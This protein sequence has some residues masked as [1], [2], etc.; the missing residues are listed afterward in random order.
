MINDTQ[1]LL[2]TAVIIV[3]AFLPRDGLLAAIS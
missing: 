2:L 1:G 3:A